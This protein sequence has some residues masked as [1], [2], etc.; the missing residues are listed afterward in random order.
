[1][2][3]LTPTV[4]KKTEFAGEIKAKIFTVVPTTSSDTIDL[5][6]HFDTIHAVIPVIQAGM[7]AALTG[8]QASFSGTTVTLATFEQ[9]GTVATDWTG[10]VIRVIVLGS[11]YGVTA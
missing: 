3:A 7:D 6:T 8:V 9:D 1:M 11:D 5:S 4:V 2:A 10:A